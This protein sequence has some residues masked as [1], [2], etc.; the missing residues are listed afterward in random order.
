MPRKYPSASTKTRWEISEKNSVS[1]RWGTGYLVLET[2]Y[3]MCYLSLDI[4]LNRINN[5][6]QL[7][8]NKTDQCMFRFGG[9]KYLLFDWYSCYIYK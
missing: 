6:K 9:R 1:L 7:E 3:N 4:S 2:G 8:N 5:N